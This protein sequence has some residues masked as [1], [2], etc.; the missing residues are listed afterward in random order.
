MKRKTWKSLISMAVMLVML[1]A[2]VFSAAAQQTQE[3]QYRTVRGTWMEVADELQY[4]S[5]VFASVNTTEDAV[6]V[7]GNVTTG[8]DRTVSMTLTVE[9]SVNNTSGWT[10]VT[11]QTWAQSISTIGGLPQSMSRYYNDPVSEYFYRSNFFASCYSGSVLLE[12]V[13]VYSPG[14]YYRSATKTSSETAADA[15]GELIYEVTQLVS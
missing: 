2:T 12:S 15:Q 11:G 14:K 6:V 10:A 1:A 7:G 8:A 13:R 4:F 3:P 9:R 5:S